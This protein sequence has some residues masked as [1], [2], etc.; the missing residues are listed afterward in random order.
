VFGYY[1]E[2]T[3]ANLHLVPADYVRKQTTAGGERFVTEALKR[4]EEQVLT[5]EERRYALEYQLFEGLRD[6]VVEQAVGLRSA[7]DAVASADAL[8]AFARVA[9]AHGYVR[10]V[11]DDSGVIDLVEA[12]HPV[13]ERML[14]GEAFVPNDLQLDRTSQQV[15][16]ITGPN[17]AGKST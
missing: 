11:V 12:R 7:A 15:L 8:Q 14:A 13:V 10:P 6:K 2:I 9:C 16:V 17:M 5:A 3:K 1:I 4:F